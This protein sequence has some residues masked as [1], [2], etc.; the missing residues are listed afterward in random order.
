MIKPGVTLL[1]W[2]AIALFVVLNDIVGDT[3]IGVNLTVRAVND[4]PVALAGSASTDE[5][6]SVALTLGG[7]DVEG[8]SLTHTVVQAPAH[9]TL[10]GTAPNLT[11][12]PAAPAGPEDQEHQN[13]HPEHG[14]CRD[15]SLGRHV[16]PGTAAIGRG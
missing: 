9:G 2:L 6:I 5:D 7:T 11:Y 4:A 13:G 16:A 1:L 14:H 12:T 8:D 15:D 3:W 10:S